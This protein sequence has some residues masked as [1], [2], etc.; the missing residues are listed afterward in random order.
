MMQTSACT[1]SRRGAQSGSWTVADQ[2]DSWRGMA[3]LLYPEERLQLTDPLKRDSHHLFLRRPALQLRLDRCRR[4]KLRQ[5]A[6][7]LR[8]VVALPLRHQLVGLG[9]RLLE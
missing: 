6:R 3:S 1:F 9:E 5:G 7:L 2:T 4:A 8:L